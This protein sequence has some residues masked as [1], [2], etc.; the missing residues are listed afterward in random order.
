MRV[1]LCGFGPQLPRVSGTAMLAKVAFDVE[2]TNGAFSF[3]LWGN[4]QITPSGSYYSIAL[5]DAKGNI[6]QSGAYDLQLPANS[7]VDL[8]TLT[9]LMNPGYSYP[10]AYH[11]VIPAAGAIAL[12]A[13]GWSQAVTFDVHLTGNVSPALSGFTPA[14]PVQFIIRQD[15]TGNRT[16]TWPTNVKNPPLINTAPNS[17]TTCNFT[18][19]ANGLLYPAQGWN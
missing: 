6:V 1:Q 14:Q 12:S 13:A 2:A 5:I 4:D 18:V 11:T 9:P 19:D 16:W 7:T 17:I 10:H 3:K 8:S 15:A